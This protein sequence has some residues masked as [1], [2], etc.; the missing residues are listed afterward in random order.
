MLPRLTWQKLDIIQKIASRIIT[1][2][3][4]QSH[5]VPLQLQLGLESLSSRRN[6]RLTSLINDIVL[7][8]VHPFFR[9]F[10]TTSD[11]CQSGNIQGKKLESRRLSVYGRTVFN[12]ITS[13]HRASNSLVE[14]ESGGH[15]STHPSSQLPSAAIS[16]SLFLPPLSPPE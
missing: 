9:D 15:M 14:S 16:T 12:E 13:S 8:K 6:E 7:G 2:A 3:A 10:F 11:S 1:D 4:P 5:S